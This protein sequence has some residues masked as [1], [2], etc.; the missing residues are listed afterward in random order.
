M[1]CNHSKYSPGER[2]VGHDQLRLSI[3]GQGLERPRGRHAAVQGHC[4]IQLKDPIYPSAPFTVDLLTVVEATEP[5]LR[6]ESNIADT[7]I[8]SSR[9]EDGG[10]TFDD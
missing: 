2:S 5:I 3:R 6:P 10:L 1:A 4:I 9:V 8:I 7:I